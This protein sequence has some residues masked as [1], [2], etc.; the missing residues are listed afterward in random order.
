M[1]SPCLPDD[2]SSV[3]RRTNMF[4]VRKDANLTDEA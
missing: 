2:S 1:L 4:T 3:A